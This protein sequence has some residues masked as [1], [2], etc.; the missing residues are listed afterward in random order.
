MRSQS[1]TRV[2]TSAAALAWALAFSVPGFAQA[3]DAPPAE[4]DAAAQDE[5]SEIVVTG[6]RQSLADAQSVKR[7]SAQV[8]DAISAEDIGKF[9][10]KNIGE[11][12]QRVTGVQITRA[13]G[14]GQ[15]VSIRGADPSLNRVEINGQTALST[16]VGSSRAV[17]FRDLPVEFVS[18]VEV[19][20]SATAD[21]TEG[22]LGG[23]VRVITRRPFDSNKPFIA[24]SV[25]GIYGTLADKVDPKLALIAS[26]LFNNDT[27]GILVSATYENRSLWYDQMRTT[28]WRQIDRDPATAG[29]QPLDLNGDGSGDFYPDI[30]RPVINRESTKRGAISG[31][32][33]WRPNS[34]F[35]A[36][37]EG[38]YTRSKMTL[39]SQFL[40]LNTVQ[41]VANG[42]VDPTRTTIGPDD[43]ATSVTFIGSLAAPNGLA[44]SYRNILGTQNRNTFNSQAGFD[45]TMGRLTL[46]ARAGYARSKA[47]NNEINATA[48][49]LGISSLTIDYDNDQQAPNITLP[50]DQT[51]SQGLNQLIVLRRPRYNDQEEFD[52]RLDAEFKPDGGF[53]TSLKA[54]I[55][56]RVLTA[57]S[58]Y[59][60][61]SLT[62]NGYNGQTITNTYGTG[63][64]SNVTLSTVPS[65]Q[66]TQQ[67]RDL[68]AA[69]AT[70]GDHD[71]FGNADLGYDG[72]IRRWLNLGM[73]VA[74][75][76]GIPDPFVNPVPL[77]TWEVKDDNFAGYGQAAFAIEGGVRIT[78]VAGLRVVDTRTT[79]DGFQ[80]R[81][82]T[83]T[84]VSFEGHYTEFLPSLNLKAELIPGKLQLRA[85]ATE[86]LAR[87]SPAQLA[88]RFALDAVGLT[89]SRGNPGLEPYRARQYDLGIEFYPNRTG[90]LS[91]T[92]FRKEIGS[93]IQNGSEAYV[94]PTTGVTYTVT[95]P[96]NGS[97]KVT[98]NGAEVGGQYVLDFLPGA[99]GNLGVIANYT[100]SK[101][102]GYADRD[103]FTGGA[104]S[105][106]GLSRH[107]YNLSGFYE[108]SVFNARVSYNWRSKYLIT[109]RGRG[110]NPEFGEAYGQWDASAGVNLNQNVSLFFEGVN[111][112]NAVRAEN[113]NSI[114]RR[115]I[116][117]SFGRRFYAGVRARF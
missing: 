17:E 27:M 25:Q 71:F 14:E 56:K 79:S 68:V 78:G 59:F 50:L 41:N 64:S 48:A 69:N 53:F 45:W 108:D 12:L 39:D 73:D 77:D 34:D 110:N 99:L 116:I 95:V 100:Y 104:L 7:N 107:S 2:M 36:F 60:D 51:T 84:P 23:T 115:T 105:F 46:Q 55:Q 18:R 102:S 57:D 35:R 101:D 94:E 96:V 117:E 80:V 67:I 97:S 40:Q 20:K 42:G 4:T 86:V 87:P 92:Y 66:L 81:A 83:V 88:P 1:S 21:M 16:V 62:L 112:T 31:V 89:G 52:G 44:V 19:V 11:A 38:T 32:F 13:A 75:A 72:G 5:A 111:L 85:T 76:V 106:P 109:S 8:V 113:A 22:G 26:T 90:Y 47:Y 63:V 29:V 43:T 33:E 74:D 103:V 54:G 24:G 37:L 6:I 91:A 98:I 93:F 58:R 82:G 10:D 28:G 61:R 30:P 3:Q 114:Y 49:A 15:G 65:A 9:P 70:L